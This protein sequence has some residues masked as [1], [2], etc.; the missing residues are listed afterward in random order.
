MTNYELV[1]I[2]NRAMKA[3]HENGIAID[4][5]KWLGLYKGYLR[6]KSQGCKMT[7]IVAE[8]SKE[9]NICE[10]KVYK[11]VGKLGKV[12]AIGAVE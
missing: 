3:L 1:S 11:L 12:C 9:Y 10:R 6:M 4:D 5:Y 2:C 8:L 7:Y